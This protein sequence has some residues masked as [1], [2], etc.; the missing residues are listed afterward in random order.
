MTEKRLTRGKQ[1]RAERDE[2]LRRQI[3]DGVTRVRRRLDEATELAADQLV[4]VLTNG[5]AEP[6][7]VAAIKL[8]LQAGGHLVERHKTEGAT[9]VRVTYAEDAPGTLKRAAGDV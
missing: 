8:A 2:A 1:L 6:G 3:V 5:T 4:G 7:L 9:E